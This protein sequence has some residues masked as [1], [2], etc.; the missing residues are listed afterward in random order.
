MGVGIVKAGV[1]V[2]VEVGVEKAGVMVG[3][4]V[5]L[6]VVLCFSLEFTTASM[7]NK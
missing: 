2:G 4:W 3:V 1:M 6:G 5:G 7:M